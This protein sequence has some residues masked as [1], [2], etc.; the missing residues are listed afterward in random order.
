MRLILQFYCCHICWL[1]LLV[2]GGHLPYDCFDIYKNGQHQTGVYSIYPSKDLSKPV[3]V[4]CDMDLKGGGWT[5]TKQ[6]NC[7]GQHYLVQDYGEVT[8]LPTPLEK[9]HKIHY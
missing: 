8:A 5:V 2:Q 4:K 9:S 1:I 6:I 7:N 3:R